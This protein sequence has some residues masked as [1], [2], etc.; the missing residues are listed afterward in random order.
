MWKRTFLTQETLW[1]LVRRW[2]PMAK[3]NQRR[4]SE[5]ETSVM[6]IYFVSSPGGQIRLH[7]GGRS[8]RHGARLPAPRMLYR[9]PQPWPRAPR[10]GSKFLL[11]RVLNVNMDGILCHV[12]ITCH[13]VSSL[14]DWCWQTPARC[15]VLS[16]QRRWADI[17]TLYMGCMSMPYLTVTSDWM[18]SIL[19]GIT[20]WCHKP[21]D[22][23]SSDGLPVIGWCDKCHV[24][25][26]TCNNTQD[27]TKSDG[28]NVI[29]AL[30]NR[31]CSYYIMRC[32]F[33]FNAP[34]IKLSHLLVQI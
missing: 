15:C 11:V 9:R 18:E 19:R 24:M 23:I 25:S 7:S 1:R 12:W 16:G 34:Y 30:S 10:A 6:F 20:G 8:P 29:D 5:N 27:R 17:K 13:P 2:T 14:S 3:P 26:E 4:M 32:R 28:C 21:C 31:S 22:V 33:R